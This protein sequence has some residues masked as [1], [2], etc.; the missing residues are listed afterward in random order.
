MYKKR[1]NLDVTPGA[2]S[3]VI[4]VSQYDAG[5]RTIEFVLFS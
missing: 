4:H 3:K 2:E 1:I 5:S